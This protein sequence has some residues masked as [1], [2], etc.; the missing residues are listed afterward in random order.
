MH[1]HLIQL[2]LAIIVISFYTIPV[3][4]IYAQTLQH[5]FISGNIKNLQNQFEIEDMSAIGRISLSNTD[6]FTIPDSLG[7]F[8]INMVLSKSGYFRIGRNILYLSPGDSLFPLLDYNKPEQAVFS[9]TNAQINDYLKATPFPMSGSYLAYDAIIKPTVEETVQNIIAFANERE[10]MLLSLKHIPAEFLGL[11]KARIKADIVNSIMDIYYEFPDF[12]KMDDN[13]RGIFEKGFVKQRDTLILPFVDA[14]IDSNYLN[15][16]VYQKI[17]YKLLASNRALEGDVHYKKIVE[18]LA[19]QKL[20]GKMRSSSDK[21]DTQTINSEIEKL[22]SLDYREALMNVLK[23]TTNY[24]N[25]DTAINFW[26]EDRTGQK[27]SLASLKGKIILIDFWATWCGPC[28]AAF[29]NIKALREKYRNDAD[30]V[31][32]SVSIDENKEKWHMAAARY[33]LGDPDWIVDRA[34]IPAY[35]VEVIPRTILIDNDFRIAAFRGP[36]PENLSELTRLIE[37]LKVKGN[38]K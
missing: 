18:W 27:I 22:T 3:K 17:G 11:E 21:A 14:F 31:I 30:I 6:N 38:K 5:V 12:H 4:A 13:E 36:G 33:G 26:S 7:N 34:T 25:G 9:G 10:K 23:R 37:T 16:I 15:L 32:L 1:L 8:S 29:P 35:Q 24:G 20:F 19:A 2:K 28:I